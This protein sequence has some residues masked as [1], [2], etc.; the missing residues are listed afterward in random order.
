MERDETRN[1]ACPAMHAMRTVKAVAPP[2]DSR[3]APRY[4]GAHLV[5]AFAVPLPASAHTLDID[6]LA[7]LM[8]G[9]PSDGFRAL[10]ALRDRL[11]AGFGVKTSAA[12]RETLRAEQAE[13]IDF[14]RVLSRAPA[15]LVVGDSD[16]HLDFQC[17][18]L[19]RAI[20]GD[21]TRTELVATTVVHCHNRLG[22]T[23]LRVIAPFHR[24]V[25]RSHL[26]RA[27]LALAAAP[28]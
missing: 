20:P 25:V 6:T 18:L 7:Q 23:Y 11:M 16:R 13:H 22:R 28:A 1:T 8:F 5:D 2:A 9:N 19:R 17:S 14:F 10:L 27:A 24:A 21:G 15:E 3:I 4:A 12:M 26:S